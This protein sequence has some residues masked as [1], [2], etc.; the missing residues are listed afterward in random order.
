MLENAIVPRASID[1]IVGLRSESLRL[2]REGYAMLREAR[3]LA[4][5]ASPQGYLPPMPEDAKRYLESCSERNEDDFQASMTKVVDQ[6][7]WDNLIHITGIERLMDAQ[8]RNEFRHQ[9]RSSPP[10]VTVENCMATIETLMLDARHIFLRGIANV[11][12]RLD[13]RFR[14]H[15]AFSI[16]SKIIFDMAFD[17]YGSW[18]GRRCDEYLR[19]VERTFHVI[20]GR[21]QP[22][23][24][25][26]I[27]GA[28]DDQRKGYRAQSFEAQSEYF[29]AKAF[30]NG[31]LHVWFKRDDL[32]VE[33]NKLLAEYY[34]ATLGDGSDETKA[35]TKISRRQ[36]SPKTSV[37]F[38]RPTVSPNESST[39]PIFGRAIASS[40]QTLELE[41]FPNEHST[42]AASSHALKSSLASPSNSSRTPDMPLFWQWTFSTYPRI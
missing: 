30:K 25:A 7:I 38:R 2:F 28:I 32:V 1:E 22:E 23:R 17:Q 14:T 9:L 24:Y 39:K 6:A 33:V 20:E 5:R 12:A 21:E 8:A 40:N 35:A 29:R 36:A 41:L 4:D 18:S 10:E 19:D 27:I 34:G 13:R 31:N 16:G 15:D 42:P 11:F 37:F 3:S 26:G